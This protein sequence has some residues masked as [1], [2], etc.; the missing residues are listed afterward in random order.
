MNLQQ[1]EYIVAVDQFRN[2]SK[3]A[4]HCHVTQA[5]LSGMVKKLE[6]ELGVVI[7]DRKAKP[8]LT[9]DCGQELIR[10]ARII[11]HHARALRELSKTVQQHISGRIRLGIIPTIASSLL[12]R[13]LGPVHEAYPDLHLDVVERTTEAV[14]Q[15]LHQGELD[16]GIIAT[17]W[18]E[19]DFEEHVLYY[20]ALMVYGEVAQKRAY[21]MPEEIKEHRVW[22][23]EEGHCLREQ[24]IHLCSLEASKQNSAAFTFQAN[25]FDTLLNMVDHYGGLTLLPELNCAHLDEQRRGR[26]RSFQSPIPVREVSWI[27]VRPFARHRINQALSQKITEI[28][29]P[30]LMTRNYK[31]AELV[32]AQI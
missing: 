7:F 5:T 16:A 29:A 10:E 25:S 21:V 13:I 17:P 22:L 12:P 28:I 3:A 32:I 31:N 4:E 9:T 15:A 23:F 26:V 27:Y 14:V 6:Q 20:E 11:L 30:Q 1:L 24:F 19:G 8:I 2:F 18:P